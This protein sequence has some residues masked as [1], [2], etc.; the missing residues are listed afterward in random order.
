MKP[1]HTTRSRIA[2]FKGIVAL[3]IGALLLGAGCASSGVAPSSAPTSS[4]PVVTAPTPAVVSGRPE[5]R[6][7]MVADT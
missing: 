4:A 7:Y 5:I 1:M 2:A 3:Q 6:Y